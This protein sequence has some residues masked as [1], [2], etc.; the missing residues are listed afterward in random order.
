MATHREPD[1]RR[2]HVAAHRRRR[3][4]RATTEGV[5]SNSRLTATTAAVLFVLLA[6][7]GITILRV[8]SLLAL[9][10]FVGMLLVPPVLVKLGS[11]GWRF[12]RYYR[13]S[14]PYRRKGPPPPLLRLLGPFVAALTVVV[15]GSGIALVLAPHSLDSRLL[16][17]HKASFVLWFGAMA[18]HVLGHAVETTRLAPLDW[19]RRTRRDVA[20]AT[21]RQWLTVTSLLAGTLL[22]IAMLGPASHFVLHGGLF[23]R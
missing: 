17:V 8:R 4:G 15:F 6:V 2:R 12:V 13:G 16:L 19:A 21:A 5:E 3:T 23:R 1:L 20:G 7:E 14:P 18:I 10:V 11:T 22:G 9:H